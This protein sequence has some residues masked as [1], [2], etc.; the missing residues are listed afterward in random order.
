M[1]KRDLLRILDAV[2]NDQEIAIDIGGCSSWHYQIGCAAMASIDGKGPVVLLAEDDNGEEYAD[3]KGLETRRRFTDFEILW[4]QWIDRSGEDKKG[5]INVL[6]RA[7]IDQPSP[8][9][10]R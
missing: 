7:A 5:T 9:A 10:D 1:K 6:P 8:G 4:V 2:D 3:P